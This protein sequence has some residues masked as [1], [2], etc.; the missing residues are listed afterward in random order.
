MIITLRYIG[1]L[2]WRDWETIAL[3]IEKGASVNAVTNDNK[4][5]L[6]CASEFGNLESVELLIEKGASVNS[7][8]TD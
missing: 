4:I 6:H 1:H 8:T 7:V 5:P 2:E 3:L